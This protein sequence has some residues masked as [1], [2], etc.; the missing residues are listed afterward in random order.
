M[1]RDTRMTTQTGRKSVLSANFSLPV[2]TKYAVM[3]AIVIVILV[4]EYLQSVNYEISTATVGAIILIVAYAVFNDLQNYPAP[5][6][7]PPS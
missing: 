5:P 1:L 4:A 6:T 7:P 2:W 3:A